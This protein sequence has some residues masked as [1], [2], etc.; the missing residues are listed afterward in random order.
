MSVQIGKMFLRRPAVVDH[1]AAQ[2]VL[3]DIVLFLGRIIGPDV[4]TEEN[5]SAGNAAGTLRAL[6]FQLHGHPHPSSQDEA[7]T[8]E[9]WHAPIGSL[10]C[11]S[12]PNRN[13]Q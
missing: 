9:D 13:E 1:L 2:F 10:R 5:G 4:E 3:S 12:H 8:R 11:P 6:N 7:A